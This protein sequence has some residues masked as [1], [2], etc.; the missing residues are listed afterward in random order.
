MNSNGSPI[1]N[2]HKRKPKN[3]IKFKIP[4]N[5]EQKEAKR[6][7]LNN[8]ITV[9]TGK[10][11]SG[12]TLLACNC[13]LDQYFTKAVDRIVIVRSTLSK[14]DIG[15]LPGDIRDKME[16][17]MQPITANMHL[18]YDK[19]K[20][21]KMMDDGSIDIVPLAFMR[22]RTFTNTFIIV[23]EVQ[24]IT[25]EQMEMI[26]SRIGVGSTMVL[27]GDARQN[28]FKKKTDSGFDDLISLEGSVLEFATY[29]LKTNHR[30]RIVDDIL[31]E[32]E[33]KRQETK[34]N[35]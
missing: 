35:Q 24:N 26:L 22:G 13:A 6:I 10:A 8:A 15:F 3:P 18:L 1:S 29:E 12:K 16:P 4:L 23:D 21:T 14:E 7:I 33:K 2:I 20:V 30:H 5:K 34:L 28:D 32:Y 27:C 19:D 25:D 9:L 31:R 11:G 17:Y